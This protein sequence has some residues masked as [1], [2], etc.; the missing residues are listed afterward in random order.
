MI[1]EFKLYKV[2]ETSTAYRNF[3]KDN[4]NFNEVII[5]GERFLSKDYDCYRVIQFTDG[6][7]LK[8]INGL[9]LD[10]LG[11]LIKKD[12]LELTLDCGYESVGLD[13]PKNYLTMDIIEDIQR[14]N[15]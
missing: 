4:N 1:L 15:A 14:L 3:L 7:N 13:I 10:E 11:F 2:K 8:L 9:K 12:D 5:V 6:K